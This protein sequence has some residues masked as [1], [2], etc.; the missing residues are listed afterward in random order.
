M[1]FRGAR[2][3]GARGEAPLMPLPPQVI[4]KDLPC[5]L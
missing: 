2:G 5:Y 4:E 3:G 1:P